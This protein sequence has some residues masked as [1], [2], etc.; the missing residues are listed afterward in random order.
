MKR[1]F[2]ALSL[3]L[4]LVFCTSILFAQNILEMKENAARGEAS[5]QFNLGI[6]YYEGKGVKQDFSQAKLWYEKAATQ[7][8]AQAQFNLGLMYYKGA[9][10]KQDLSQAKLWYEKSAAQ[11]YAQAKEALKKLKID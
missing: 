10:V 6:M 8:Y 2:L 7:G 4:S 1:G 11:G 5:A 9:G 3:G